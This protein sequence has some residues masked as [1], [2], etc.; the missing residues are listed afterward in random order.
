MMNKR[1]LISLLLLSGVCIFQACETDFDPYIP[2]NP[3]PV[4]YGIINPDDS[5]Y[6]IRLT[7]SF[8]G[9]GSA[10]DY[11]QIQDSIYYPEARVYLET[12]L[13]NNTLLESV[14]LELVEI[15][16]REAGIF[17]SLPN[18][19]YQT[20]VSQISL[21]PEHFIDKGIPYNAYL[22]LRAI[23][24]GFRDTLFAE[25]RLKQAPKIINPRANFQKVYFYSEVPFQMEWTHTLQDNYF[26]IQVIL[27]YREILEDGEREAVVDWVLKGIEYNE[28]SIP[29]GRNNF[30]IYYFRAEHFYSQL[31]AA[32]KVDPEVKGRVVRNVDFVIL[33]SDQTVNNYISIGEIADDYRGSSYS[34][35]TNGH[36][37]FTAFNT[38]GVYDLHLGY[39]ELDSLAFG[40][41]TKHL[42]FKNWE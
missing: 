34:N 26:E 42:N 15:E 4:V 5:L 31:R 11:A 8:V 41:Y 28:E 40:R 25:T 22:H 10:Y 13:H 30:Y 20:D 16:Q 36:G 21:R 19:V 9:P 12:Y 1:T 32:I 2:S 6:Q 33:T 3:T 24:P 7:K 18:Y 39:R 17:A 29:G 27:E 37:I 35:V 38:S 14:E 23:I